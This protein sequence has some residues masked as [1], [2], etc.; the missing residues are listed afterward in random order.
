MKVYVCKDHDGYWPIKVTS[1]VVADNRKEA[2]ELI[3]KELIMR[4]LKPYKEKEYILN[5]IDISVSNA[6]IGAIVHDGY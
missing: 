2:R 3:D 5:E 6:Y 4:Q 1:I